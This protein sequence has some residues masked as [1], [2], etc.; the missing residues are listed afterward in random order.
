MPICAQQQPNGCLA[1][2]RG[3]LRVHGPTVSPTA[4]CAWQD[5]KRPPFAAQPNS[6]IVLVLGFS[7]DAVRP[8][9]GHD[10]SRSY[11]DSTNLVMRCV[12]SLRRVN[13]TLPIHLLV[14]GERD[15]QREA[16]IASQGVL[17]D[18]ATALP[19]APAWASPWMRGTFAKL[20]ALTLTQYQRIILLDS[21]TVAVKNI[22]HLS[23]APPPIAGYFH[24]G[25]GG[26]TCPQPSSPSNR[27]GDVCLSGVLNSGVLALQ[28]DALRLET[29][30]RLLGS[31]RHEQHGERSMAAAGT[32]RL[33]E[34]DGGKWDTSDQ[35]LWHALYTQVH[36]L[37]FGYNANADANMTDE[38][39]DR[40][41]VLHDLVVQRKRGWRHT[42]YHGLVNTLTRDAQRHFS[43]R[44]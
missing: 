9:F 27:W 39:W 16:V 17:I 40:V 7:R 5:R 41:Y 30:R 38:G 44:T 2:Q 33:D 43:T 23:G 34:L 42:G 15:L 20:G 13:T 32:L 36:E 14:S 37:P 4:A 35:R 28:P 11:V 10:P 25:E 29:A 22:D 24:F 19:R 21:D 8:S 12:L 31:H 1:H 26:Y 3:C 18:S 6:A